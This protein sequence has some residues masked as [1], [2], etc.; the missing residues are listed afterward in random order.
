MALN[1]DLSKIKNRAEIQK[2][3]EAAITDQM[4]WFTMFAG[5]GEITEANAGEFYARV[6]LIEKLSGAFLYRDK[7]PMYITPADVRR[8]IGLKTNVSTITRPAFIKLKVGNFM[9]EAEARK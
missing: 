7:E 9:R 2:G 3:N 8:R 4:I 1:W 5:I 6:H